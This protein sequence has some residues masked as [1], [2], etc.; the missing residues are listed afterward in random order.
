MAI[1]QLYGRARLLFLR[2]AV[3]MCEE[4]RHLPNAV[5]TGTLPRP[6]SIVLFYVERAN[7]VIDHRGRAT[8]GAAVAQEGGSLVQAVSTARR[9]G[10]AAGFLVDNRSIAALIQLFLDGADDARHLLHGRQRSSNIL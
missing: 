7:E 8:V 3:A 1:I 9:M 6:R 4:R 10:G 5:G 2:A